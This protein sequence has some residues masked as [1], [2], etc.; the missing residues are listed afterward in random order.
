MTKEIIREVKHYTREALSLYDDVP[1]ARVWAVA[2][3]KVMLTYFAVLIIITGIGCTDSSGAADFKIKLETQTEIQELPLGISNPLEEGIA[4]LPDILQDLGLSEKNGVAGFVVDMVARRNAEIDSGRDDSAVKYNFSELDR[5]IDAAVGKGKA[6]L[7]LVIN[8]VGF[9]KFTDGKLRQDRKTYL[10]DGPVFRQAY[11][12]YLTELVNHATTYGRA[13]SGNPNWYV[14]RWNLF[15]EVF[16]EWKDTF[17]ENTAAA[18]YAEFALDSANILRQLSPKSKIVLGG[19]ASK[20][21]LRAGSPNATFYIKIFEHFRIANPD[22]IPFDFFESHWFPAYTEYARNREGLE[23]VKELHNFLKQ[24]GYGDKQVIIRAGATYTGMDMDEPKA[25]M[26]NLQ[27]ESQQAEFLFKRFIY[28]F[29]QGAK[30][31]PWSLIVEHKKYHGDEHKIFCFTGLIYNGFPKSER[32]DPRRQQPCP[33]P[34][35]G[36]KKLSYYTFKFLIEKQRGTDFGNIESINTAIPNV[37]LYK[38]KR[39]I[40]PLYV[41]W[42]DYFQDAGTQKTVT[43][44]LPDIK[45]ANV[46]VTDAL[47]EFDGV[48]QTRTNHLNETDY[49]HFFPSR[50]LPVIDGSITLTLDDAPV[51]VEEKR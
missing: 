19:L 37:Y 31:I 14:I 28:N 46:Q 11:R 25:L 39:E 50:T 30:A 23:V 33:D 18:K 51:F 48:F 21:D 38:L 17:G 1:G 5:L 27:G 49:P 3:E 22:F 16:S 15:N 29:A 4:I 35:Y 9:N 7:W 42:W 26:N 40:A 34:G 47:P 45:T 20:F 41:A 36:V 44:L 43:L 32:C 2:M 12:R 13:Q 10:P 6:N 8:P 24:Q